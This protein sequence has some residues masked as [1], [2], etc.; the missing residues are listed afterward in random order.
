MSEEGFFLIGSRFVVFFWSGGR[1][2]TTLTKRGTDNLAVTKSKA[3]SGSFSELVEA[4]DLTGKGVGVTNFGLQTLGDLLVPGTAPEVGET[5]V[6]LA[7]LGLASIEA[8]SLS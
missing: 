1:K 6:E 2:G 8:Q 7:S 4:L 3:R 5:V